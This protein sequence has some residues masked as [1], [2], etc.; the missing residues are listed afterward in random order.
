[1]V[2]QPVDTV[3]INGVAKEQLAWYIVHVLLG[4]T[5]HRKTTDIVENHNH[6]EHVVTQGVTAY[7]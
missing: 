6:R 3:N 5:I 7:R 1:M 4:K 2:T